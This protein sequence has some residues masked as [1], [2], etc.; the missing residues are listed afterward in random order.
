[1]TG[2]SST[3]GRVTRVVGP[4]E[5]VELARVQPA[6]ARV[7]DREVEDGEEVAAGLVLGVD[8]D[9]RPLAP[10]EH[11]LDVEGMPAEAV[12]ELLCFLVGRSLEVDPGEAVLV[13]L[14]DRRPLG[15]LDHAGG[16]AARTDA[17]QIGHRY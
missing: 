17:G 6:D 2:F 14:S 16:S 12:C 15:G 13:E 4:D 8:V 5:G 7:E 1:M 9:L 3:A 11:V 10:R